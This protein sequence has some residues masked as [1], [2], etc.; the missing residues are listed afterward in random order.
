MTHMNCLVLYTGMVALSDEGSPT[1]AMAIYKKIANDMDTE[2]RY[3]FLNGI[4][5]QLR[6]PNSHTQYFSK[7]LLTLFAEAE[8][9]VLQEQIT[10]VM[11]ERLIVHKPHPWGL[12]IT[13]IE[14]IKNEDYKFWQLGITAAAPE[15]E[16]LFE[17]VAKSF[18][19][20]L[21]EAL[22]TEESSQAT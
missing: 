21:K 4:A 17:A 9:L 20:N 15:I 16:H 12:F 2:G 6:Y 13:F 19:P 18:L 14:L 1:N 10:R 5:N 22:G 3:L 8:T 11:L 7:L